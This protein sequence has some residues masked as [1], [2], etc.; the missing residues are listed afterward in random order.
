MRTQFETFDELLPYI[1][2]LILEG[3]EIEK[4][5]NLISVLKHPEFPT[6]YVDHRNSFRVVTDEKLI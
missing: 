2:K 5:V 3:Y 4:S 6:L 1:R